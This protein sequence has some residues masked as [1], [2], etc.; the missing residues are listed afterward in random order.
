MTTQDYKFKPTADMMNLPAPLT[1]EEEKELMKNFQENRNLF[2]L[3][4]LRLI[5]YT[6]KKFA[7]NKTESEEFFSVGTIGLLKA[8]NTF[9]PDKKIKFSTYASRCIQNEILMYMRACKK[10]NNTIS[11]DDIV[12]T[13][14]NG[15][16]LT[17]MD[18]LYDDKS[19]D[20]PENFFNQDLVSELLDIALNR[21]TYKE[22]VIFLYSVLGGKTQ[23]KT[24]DFMNLS[25]SYISRLGI[26]SYKKIRYFF[27]QQ[28]KVNIHFEKKISFLV[29]DDIFIITFFTEFYPQ[30]LKTVLLEKHKKYRYKLFFRKDGTIRVIMGMEHKSFQILAEI[31]MALYS[32]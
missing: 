19:S 31:I 4:N 16:T 32:H 13:D 2:I 25:Q 22:Q 17:Y 7:T 29:K 15:N 21:L 8:V 28:E 9:N 30:N 6:V 14:K 3:R 1:N 27:E 23:R 24:A 26:R 12:S 10:H 5:V 11:L 20:F 18:I